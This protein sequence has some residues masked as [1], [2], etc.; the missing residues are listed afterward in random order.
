[1]FPKT[2]LIRDRK[3]FTNIKFIWRHSHDEK[4][5][6]PS[7]C[8]YDGPLTETQVSDLIQ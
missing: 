4:D 6:S 5:V 3:N 1:M 7:N 8:L 2:T